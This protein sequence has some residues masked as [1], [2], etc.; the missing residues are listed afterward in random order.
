MPARESVQ[1][2]R[3]PSLYNTMCAG[4]A[5]LKVSARDGQE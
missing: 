5:G 4:L 3:D 1:D 2:L